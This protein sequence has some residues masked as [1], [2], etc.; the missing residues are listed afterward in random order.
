VPLAVDERQ[1]HLE[2]DRLERKKRVG[3]ARGHVIAATIIKMITFRNGL[4]LGARTRET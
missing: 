1:Q 2:D 3:I 4:G